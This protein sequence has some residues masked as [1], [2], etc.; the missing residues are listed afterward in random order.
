M[1]LWNKSIKQSIWFLS[2]AWVISLGG[3]SHAEVLDRVIAK[4]N[5]EII[6]LSEVQERTVRELGRLRSI[7]NENIPVVEDIMRK[8]LNR[9]IEDIL[10]LGQGKKIGITIS[11]DRVL[12]ALDEVKNTNSLTDEELI[13][14]LE[15]ESQTLEEYKDTIRDQILLS[16]VISI[17]IK[18]RIV[19]SEKQILR[20]YENNK[21]EFWQAGKVKASHILFL[22]DETLTQTEKNTKEALAEKV[23]QKIRE[24]VDFVDLAKAY[25]E[26]VSADSGGDLGEL[27]RGKMVPELERVVFSMREGEVSGIVRSP[28]GLHIIKVNQISPGRTIGLEDV[29]S[30]IVN[31]E[32]LKRFEKAFDDYVAKLKENAFIENYLQLAKKSAPIDSKSIRKNS[33][34]RQGE[35]YKIS[36]ILPPLKLNSGLKKAPSDPQVPESSV[37]AGNKKSV[38]EPS[39]LM[40]LEKRL[41]EI[42]KMRVGNIIS[43]EEY[44]QQKRK[45]LEAL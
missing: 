39:D 15:A 25:S 20:Y 12:A 11:D 42:K 21:K 35:K 2:W 44:Q 38:E 32:R 8:V 24:G 5:D 41:R 27:E 29:R 33:N 45:I 6:T 40:A 30:Q 1:K 34:R 10:I 28:Y 43:E 9:M 22:M 26:D 17:E 4:V 16:K 13:A 23:L 14:M 37:L 7:E 18:N 3:I 36:N 31:A 19:V